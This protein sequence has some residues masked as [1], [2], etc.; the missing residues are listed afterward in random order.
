MI[1]WKRVEAGEYK[2]ENNRFNIT[3]EYNRMYGGDHWV[4]RDKENPD[5]NEG[6]YHE[7]TLF[8]CKMKAEYL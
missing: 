4:L 1:K 2:S 3:K 7:K 6:T 8:D 5:I